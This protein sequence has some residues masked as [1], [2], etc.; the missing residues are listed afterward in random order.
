MKALCAF[1]VSRSTIHEAKPVLWICVNA[2]TSYLTYLTHA[3]GGFI[4]AWVSKRQK[5]SYLGMLAVPR[6]YGCGV[7]ASLP[8]PRRMPMCQIARPSSVPDALEIADEAFS[9]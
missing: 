5:A 6:R 1:D 3:L 2:H 7:M 8:R 9:R 4:S